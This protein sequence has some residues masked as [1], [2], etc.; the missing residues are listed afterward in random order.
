MNDQARWEQFKR[1]VLGGCV[2]EDLLDSLLQEDF[3]E[4]VVEQSDDLAE[5]HQAIQRKNALAQKRGQSIPAGELFEEAMAGEVIA[6]LRM[7]RK[8]KHSR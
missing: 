7:L 4:F 5:W 6:E 8:Q 1:E 3:L 2:D